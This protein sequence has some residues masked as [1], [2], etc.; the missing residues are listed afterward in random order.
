MTI[1]TQ[2]LR[3]LIRQGRPLPWLLATSNSWRR[4]V[5]ATHAEVCT[6]CTQPDGHPDLRFAG[7]YEGANAQ[8]QIE[9]VNALPRLLAIIDAQTAEIAEA[10]GQV[11]HMDRQNERLRIELR[12]LIRGYVNLLENGR[13]RIIDLGGQCD[14]LDVMEASDHWLKSARAALSGES[15]G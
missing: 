15:N 9:A 3:D 2:K 10:R 1:D 12:T 14:S 8:L 5:D 6:P 7:G 11:E 4:I 13:D